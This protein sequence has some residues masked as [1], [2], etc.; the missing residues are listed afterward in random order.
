[1]IHYYMSEEFN[2]RNISCTDEILP[3]RN[4]RRNVSIVT[5]EPWTNDCHN[6]H[7]YAKCKCREYTILWLYNIKAVRFTYI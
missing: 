4:S 7:P 2:L 5:I 1:M 6:N 3:G